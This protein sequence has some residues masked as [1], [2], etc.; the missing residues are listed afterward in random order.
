MKNK[1]KN[2]RCSEKSNSGLRDIVL[3][4]IVFFGYNG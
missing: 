2:W 4:N 3:V 1:G